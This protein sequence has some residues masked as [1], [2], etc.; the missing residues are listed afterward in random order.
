MVHKACALNFPE[1]PWEGNSKDEGISHFLAGT[2]STYGL[3]WYDDWIERKI[4][5]SSATKTTFRCRLY[6]WG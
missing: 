5:I 4:E 3:L 1:I 2:E 6:T